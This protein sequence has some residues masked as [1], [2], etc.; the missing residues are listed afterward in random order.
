VHNSYNDVPYGMSVQNILRNGGKNRMLDHI[1]STGGR[2][3]LAAWESG[4]EDK[5]H[6]I[7]VH[8]EDPM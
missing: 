2:P 8:E 1:R 6:I 3:V 4:E 5:P 7:R